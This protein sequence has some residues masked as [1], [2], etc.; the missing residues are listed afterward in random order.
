MI[1]S[2]FLNNESP[3]RKTNNKKV[4]L[5]YYSMFYRC[6]TQKPYQKLQ[7]QEFYYHHMYLDMSIATITNIYIYNTMIF[8]R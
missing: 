7:R 3:Y 6:H 2:M 5:G 8:F 4:S 1:P